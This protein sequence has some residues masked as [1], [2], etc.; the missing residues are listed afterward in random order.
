[1]KLNSRTIK[2]VPIVASA[3]LVLAACGSNGDDSS[4]VAQQPAEAAAPAAAPA[5]EAPAAAPAESTAE[6]APASGKAAP[7]AA[8]AD[9]KTEAAKPAKTEKKAD[10]AK[11]AAPAKSASKAKGSA[12]GN[13]SEAL[14]DIKHS[15]SPR[16]SKTANA[17]IAEQKNGATDVGV[18]KD[19][20]KLGSINMH[21][22]ALGNVL[23][24]PQVRGNL[25]AASAD[26]RPRR[27][28][29]PAH[30]HCRLRRRPG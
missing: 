5:E 18:T 19:A 3:A 23:V 13:S 16:P 28:P 29:R 17:K 25:A 30:E 24:A 9:S 2:V 6:E 27:H 11:A 14:T 12:K 1:M 10:T 20:I 22:M 7:E 8:A 4:P 15:S 26:Q 21:G